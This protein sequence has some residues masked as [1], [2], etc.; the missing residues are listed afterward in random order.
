PLQPRQRRGEVHRMLAGAAADLQHL[1]GTAEMAAQHLEDRA[2]V[3]LAGGRERLFDWG[4]HAGTGVRTCPDHRPSTA[5]RQ[6]R[7]HHRHMSHSRVL[8]IP[9]ER[10]APPAAPLRVDGLVLQP[11]PELHITLVGNAL[12]RE[13]HHVFGDR[14]GYLVDEAVAALEW[15]WTR[16][17]ER[18][19]LRRTTGRPGE[20]VTAHSVIERIR[21]PAMRQLHR[22]LGRLLGRELPLPPPHVTLFV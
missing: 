6:R 9:P 7:E 18:L 14:T 4:G 17:G 3:A 10:W 12:G 11:K 5:P 20:Q 22:S 2:G 8:P 19:L 1:P 21:L 16:T 13:L 15:N